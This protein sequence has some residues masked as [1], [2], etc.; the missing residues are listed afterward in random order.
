MSSPHNTHGFEEEENEHDVVDKVYSELIPM[1]NPSAMVRFLRNRAGDE[2]KFK[3]MDSEDW[4]IA[5]YIEHVEKKLKLLEKVD[6]Y[7]KTHT[8]EK[9]GYYFI[10]GKLGPVDSNDLP[11]KLLIC[12]AYGCDWMQIY[13]RTERTTGPEW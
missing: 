4:K 10:A 5:D 13:E 11:E 9:S 6:M 7:L 2:H 3:C 8:P 1:L 12:P